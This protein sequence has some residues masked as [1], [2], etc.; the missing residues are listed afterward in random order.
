MTGCHGGGESPTWAVRSTRRSA[1]GTRGPCHVSARGR[2]RV[3]G[4]R[5]GRV[6]RSTACAVRAQDRSRSSGRATP[7][8]R[9]RGTGRAAGCRE[10]ARQWRQHASK[11]GTPQ[12]TTGHPGAPTRRGRRR[13]HPGRRAR[14]KAHRPAA[15]TP[16]GST[17]HRESGSLV[18]HRPPAAGRPG[19]PRRC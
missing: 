16:R 1:T 10:R 18:A 17:P 12:P 7:V 11:Q 8:R 5:S 15:P 9:R 6:D 13:R 19:A 2:D 14:R 4:R 3:R